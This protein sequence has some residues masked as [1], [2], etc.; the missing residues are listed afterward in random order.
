[1]KNIIILVLVGCLLINV[2]YGRDYYRKDV[3]Y[4][5]VKKTT[6]NQ[7]KTEYKININKVLVIVEQYAKVV[8]RFLR[9][10]NVKTIK[11]IPV[12]NYFKSVQGRRV[13]SGS[14]RKY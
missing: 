5:M 6:N 14:P 4:R 11:N 1:M 12:I 13:L 2:V 7:E 9:T 8:L 10:Y 3:Y